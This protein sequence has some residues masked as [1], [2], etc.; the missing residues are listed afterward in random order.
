VR[1]IAAL[2]GLP[3]IVGAIWLSV[4]GVVRAIE[5]NRVGETS[6][7]FADAIRNSGPE[8]VFAFIRSGVDPNAPVVFSH[9][10]LTGDEPVRVVPMVLAVALH[11]VNAVMTLMSGGAR[12]DLPRNR[13][14]ICLAR[15]LGYDDIA[16]MIVRDAAIQD[17]VACPLAGNSAY[18]LLDFSE[19]D[20]T[21]SET[22]SP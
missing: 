6:G 14:A 3:A 22:H 5:R 11:N 12:M 19:S 7:S 9:P 17:A 8:Q 18:P 2:L 4:S 13:K 21:Q 20:A 15:R 16:T 1:L 10:D